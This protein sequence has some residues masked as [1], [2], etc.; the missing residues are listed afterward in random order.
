MEIYQRQE[1]SEI[2]DKILQTYV[3]N[4]DEVDYHT[5]DQLT[6]SE[7]KFSPLLN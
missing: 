3:K 6:A 2:I 4:D 1:I 5:A 7:Y